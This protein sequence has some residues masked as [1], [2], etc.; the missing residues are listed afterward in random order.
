LLDLAGVDAG[1]TRVAGREVRPITGRSWARWLR[2]PSAIIYGPDDGVGS[3]LFG[4][5]AYRVGDWKLTDVG[6][7]SWRLFDIA[8]DPGETRD[9]SLVHPDRKAALAAAWEGYAA[10][11]GIVLPDAIPYRP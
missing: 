9:L 4:S 8:R 1:A 10:R 2:D 11:V 6:D 3:E 7:G 5:R